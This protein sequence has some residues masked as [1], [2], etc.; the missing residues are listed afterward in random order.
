MLRVEKLG[1]V[2]RQGS[3]GLLGGFALESEQ[4]ITTS[5]TH[6]RYLRIRSGDISKELRSEDIP[7]YVI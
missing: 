3:Y 6:H 4:S 7:G 2:Q 1:P 5:I